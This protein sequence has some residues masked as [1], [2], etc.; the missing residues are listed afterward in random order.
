MAAAA[1]DDAEPA[2]FDHDTGTFSSPLVLMETST[3]PTPVVSLETVIA[4]AK[5]AL[6]KYRE[7][8]HGLP[9]HGIDPVQQAAYVGQIKEISPEVAA[10][11]KTLLDSATYINAAELQR[12]LEQMATALEAH[13]LVHKDVKFAL[14]A[15]D[16]ENAGDFWQKSNAMLTMYM[17]ALV[18]PDAVFI[19]GCFQSPEMAAA[20]HDEQFEYLCV[21]D[22]MY[23][24]RQMANTLDAIT[25][26]YRWKGRAWAVV[27]F[28]HYASQRELIHP[29]VRRIADDASK[30]LYVIP[31]EIRERLGL[32]ARTVTYLQTRMP[33]FLSAPTSIM[34]GANPFKG[35]GSDEFERY[36]EAYD[37][38]FKE[39]VFW[40][41]NC[42]TR[43]CPRPSYKEFQRMVLGPCA[44]TLRKELDD[45]AKSLDA[46]AEDNGE[47]PLKRSRTVDGGGGAGGASLGGVPMKCAQALDKRKSRRR[48]SR[49]RSAARSRRVS[50]SRSRSRSRNPIKY[51]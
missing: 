6:P 35:K 9:E 37:A 32:A 14:V 31:A 40:I 3:L 11:V 51:R 15:V 43:G 1:Y 44:R 38:R 34:N 23:S 42:S 30:N 20:I 41:K 19:S 47:K 5:A 13:R 33:D 17:A 27:P 12:R 22:C 26:M 49:R 50:R 48:P 16:E 18:R 10:D 28:V 7:F 36:S 2:F 25:T 8:L 29:S 4:L 46:D 45:L 21:D 39:P 24:G